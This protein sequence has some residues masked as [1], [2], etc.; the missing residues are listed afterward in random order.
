MICYYHLPESMR[1]NP[2]IGVA[3]CLGS[4]PVDLT[5]AVPWM[6]DLDRMATLA[7][8]VQGWYPIR[9]SEDNHV[10]HDSSTGKTLR[11][12]A[13]KLESG[14]VSLICFRPGAI[15]PDFVI[16]LRV[17]AQTKAETARALF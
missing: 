2:S 8:E 1:K 6:D 9:A 13:H 7:A 3:V 12:S 14:R 10:L 5:A 16:Y 15:G 11:W 4:D 17:L